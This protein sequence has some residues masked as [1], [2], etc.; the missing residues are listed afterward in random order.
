MKKTI[1]LLGLVCLTALSGCTKQKECSETIDTINATVARFDK[2]DANMDMTNPAKAAEQMK[3]LSKAV[4]DEAEK[5]NKLNPET[6]EL[7]KH[8]EDY[9]EMVNDMAKATKQLS[10]A[11]KA[12]A[13]LESGMEKSQKEL[14]SAMEAVNGA[15]TANA[16]GCAEIATKMQQAPTGSEGDEVFLKK[17]EAFGGML[18]AIKPGSPKVAGPLTQL[19]KAVEGQVALLKK[20]KATEKAGE[21]AATALDKATDAEDGL[22]SAINTFCGAP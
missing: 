3:K 5:I 4:E 20:A 16:A 21:E 18:K 8:V 10:E 13:E 11:A 6:E 22:V 1:S 2:M 7:K 19:V 17:L 9:Q 15:C 14:S 12:M